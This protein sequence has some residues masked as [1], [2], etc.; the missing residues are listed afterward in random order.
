VVTA[1]ADNR[2]PHSL[3][4]RL[5]RKR[6]DLFLGLLS[7]LNRPVAILD[8]GG[9]QNFW[10]VMGFASVGEVSVTLLNL[11]KEAISL[12]NFRSVAGDARR[13]E[14]PD[15]SFDVVFSNSV[16][17]HVGS[18]ADQLRMAEEVQRVGKRYFVQTPN[19][20]FPIEP[21]FLF[22]F[23]QFLPLASRVWLLRH[24][25]LGWH[26]RTRDYSSAREQVAGVELLSKN[27]MCAMFPKATIVEEKFG[28][29]TKSFIALGGWNVAKP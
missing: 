11:S 19:K 14:F 25:N 9:T 27:A 13:I 12:P 28:G 21:H 7:T 20:Y 8:V 29:L 3:A 23:F 16:I 6:F 22:P 18:R 4:A 26:R 2:N 17:E 24:F 10:E 1:V 15:Q 5:R